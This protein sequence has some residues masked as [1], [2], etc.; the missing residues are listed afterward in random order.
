MIDGSW[1]DDLTEEMWDKRSRSSPATHLL[2]QCLLLRVGVS[3]IQARQLRGVNISQKRPMVTV[4]NGI[5]LPNKDRLCPI[6]KGV[7]I[8]LDPEM[9]V[10]YAPKAHSHSH[11]LKV[12]NFHG[13]RCQV[14]QYR[15][16]V[17]PKCPWCIVLY[18]L[19]LQLRIATNRPK[20]SQ[21]NFYGPLQSL[22]GTPA[23]LSLCHCS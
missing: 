15:L 20:A 8:D 23:N 22:T 14:P 12:P 18:L 10:V 6:T 19:E 5:V 1:L 4:S 17:L 3:S 13:S 11:L 2:S 21:M 9:R 16:E 7:P